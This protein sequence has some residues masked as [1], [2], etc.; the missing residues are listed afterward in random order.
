M[1]PGDSG[2]ANFAPAQGMRVRPGGRFTHDDGVS[3][4]DITTSNGNLIPGSSTPTCL[5]MATLPTLIAGHG[6]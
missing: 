3:L 2:H 5:D 1:R 4:F 6:N